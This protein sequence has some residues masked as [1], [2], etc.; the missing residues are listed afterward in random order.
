M[1]GRSN[2]VT[3]R[4]Q[5]TSSYFLV[6]TRFFVFLLFCHVAYKISQLFHKIHLQKYVINCVVLARR[7]N[8]ILRL[9]YIE[10]ICNRLVLAIQKLP[11]ATSLTKTSSVLIGYLR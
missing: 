4:T 5:I 8:N 1:C 6:M 11:F 3:S 10:K 2:L 9:C 7:E